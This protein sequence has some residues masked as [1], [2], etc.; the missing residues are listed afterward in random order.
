MKNN[1]VEDTAIDCTKEQQ[2]QEYYR[3]C[4]A[5]F[6]MLGYQEEYLA[7][8]SDDLVPVMGVA[9]EEHNR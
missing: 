2:R 8:L 3:A 4:I 7:E 6:Q 9:P 1:R 5:E